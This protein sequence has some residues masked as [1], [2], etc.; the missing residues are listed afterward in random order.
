M[1]EQSDTTLQS[2]LQVISSEGP[3]QVAM[4]RVQDAGWHSFDY[5]MFE[6][7][8]L[9]L[10]PVMRSGLEQDRYPSIASIET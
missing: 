8:G 6:V 4:V 9:L 7:M 3:V 1:D 10:S 5:A 2:I